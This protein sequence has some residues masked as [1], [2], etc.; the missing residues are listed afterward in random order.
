MICILN[1]LRWRF[2]LVSPLPADS[3]GKTGAQFQRHS[4]SSECTLFGTGRDAEG[5]RT[6]FVSATSGK[7]ANNRLSSQTPWLSLARVN[8]AVLR[9]GHRVLFQRGDT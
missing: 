8:A 6:I 1:A 9:P 3:G 5:H 2:R 4:I 7:D